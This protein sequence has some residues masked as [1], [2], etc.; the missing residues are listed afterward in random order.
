MFLLYITVDQKIV[1]QLNFTQ[2][3]PNKNQPPNQQLQKQNIVNAT[4]ATDATTPHTHQL[5][6]LKKK[7]R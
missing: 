4:A 5:H 6:Q 7:T 1:S 3:I 2:T